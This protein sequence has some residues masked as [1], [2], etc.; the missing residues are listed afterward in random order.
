MKGSLL[1]RNY[2]CVGKL[3]GSFDD[4][5]I[6]CLT[7]L[8]SIEEE[9]AKPGDKIMIGGYPHQEDKQYCLYTSYGTIK[10]LRKNEAGYTI[11]YYDDL[12][13]SAGQGGAPVFLVRSTK[14]GF[15]YRI[16][17]IHAGRDLKE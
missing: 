16:I 10:A 7:Y 11:I 13:T 1:E 17:G 8:S 4:F 3:E 6:P 9:S 2:L 14:E 12:E 15:S 5:K